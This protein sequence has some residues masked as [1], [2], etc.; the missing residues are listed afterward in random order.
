MRAGRALAAAVVSV[1]ALAIPAAAQAPAEI[2]FPRPRDAI[3][4]VPGADEILLGAGFEERQFPGRVS[5]RERVEVG[6]LPDGTVVGVHVFHRLTLTGTGDFNFRIPGPVRNLE[7]LP[8][9]TSRPGLRR[10]SIIW[11]GFT[12]GERVLGAQ[13]DLYPEQEAGRLPIRVSLAITAA[14]RTLEPGET[15]DGRFEAVLRLENVTPIATGM[16]QGEVDPA[17]AA[18]ALDAI[19]AELARGGRPAPGRGGV[20]RGIPATGETSFRGAPIEAPI[21][22]KGSLHFR[23]NAGTWSVAD[24]GRRPASGEVTATFDRLLGGGKPLATEIRLTGLG[25][26]FALDQLELRATPA[27]P[28]ASVVAPPDDAA[29]WAELVRAG[30]APSGRDMLAVAMETMW[31][32][33]RLRVYDGYVGTPDPFGFA[34]TTYVYR[35]AEAPATTTV[36][37]P[38]PVRA[39]GPFGIAL[40]A[41]AGMLLLLTVALQWAHA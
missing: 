37:A 36:T 18:D 27:P 16:A 9:T 2:R 21:L 32:V 13:F 14:G 24:R 40:A 41:I 6:L 20:P 7:A 25:R 15:G 17:T 5:D 29:S 30:S 31:R 10:G 12:A 38:A 19:R 4:L 8:E 34:R 1:L 35:L 11:Q 22:V 28:K 23:L 33:A 26:G 39:L 3:A